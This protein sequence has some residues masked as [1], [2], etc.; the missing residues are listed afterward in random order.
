MLEKAISTAA[1]F[2]RFSVDIP[3]RLHMG[4]CNGKNINVSTDGR[5]T[6]IDWDF[7]GCYPSFWEY[8]RAI[9]ACGRFADDWSEWINFSLDVY[10]N[11]WAWIQML[12]IEIWCWS[13]SH[14]P[15]RFMASKKLSAT[16]D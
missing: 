2:P 16:M 15:F 4:T 10:R 12:I 5:I 13:V 7:A 11:E 8:A 6:I 9:F 3:Q 1:L 14:S